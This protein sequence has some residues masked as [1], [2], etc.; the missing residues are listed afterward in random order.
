MCNFLR[1]YAI[2]AQSAWG[3]ENVYYVQS[4]Y[5]V[6]KIQCSVFLWDVCH[7]SVPALS[8][9]LKIQFYRTCA[10]QFRDIRKSVKIV[11]YTI[12]FLFSAAITKRKIYTCFLNLYVSIISI[13]NGSTKDTQNYKT[14]GNEPNCTGYRIEMK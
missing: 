12:I 5:G 4:E 6:N 10:R 3:A 9:D 11:C 8:R 13:S 14:K 1:T 2:D 7:I